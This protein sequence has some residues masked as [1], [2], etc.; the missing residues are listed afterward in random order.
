VVEFSGT[1]GFSSESITIILSTEIFGKNPSEVE[2]LL[3]QQ[4]QLS[5]LNDY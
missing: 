1:N 3:R 4:K 2:V 5:T